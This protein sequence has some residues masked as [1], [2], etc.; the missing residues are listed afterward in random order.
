MIRVEECSR[1]TLYR[2]TDDGMLIRHYHDTERWSDP[3]PPMYDDYGHA[4][5][6]GN[7]RVDLLIDQERVYGGA[8]A[9]RR[10]PPYLHNSL[11]IL[12]KHQTPNIEAFARELGVKPSTA[13]SYAYKV[14]EAWPH[15][16]TEASRLVHP[17]ILQAVHACTATSGSLKELHQCIHG[18]LVAAREVTDLFAHIRLARACGESRKKCSDS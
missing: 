11:R 18:E 14:V 1:S 8:A 16:H 17:E 2:K 4:R 7:R 6:S 5:C 3:F 9:S 13:W 10:T 12:C 15:A